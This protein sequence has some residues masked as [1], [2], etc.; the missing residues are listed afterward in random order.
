MAGHALRPPELTTPTDDPAGSRDLSAWWWGGFLGAALVLTATV[1]GVSGYW[2]RSEQRLIAANVAAVSASLIAETASRTAAVRSQLERWGRDAGVQAALADGR[3]AL[4]AAKQKEL[5]ARL[6]GTLGIGLFTPM[7]LAPGGTGADALSFAGTELVRATLASGEVSSLEAHRLGQPD[8]HLAIAGPVSAPDGGGV[9]GVVH[10]RLP[11]ALLPSKA[12]TDSMGTR[13]LFQ[14]QTGNGMVTIPLHDGDAPP[15]GEPAFT[16]PIERTHL[17]LAAWV[18]ARGLADPQRLGWLAGLLVGALALLGV[19]LWLAQRSQ[20][21]ALGADIEAL[22]AV[23]DDAQER[24]PLRA[25]R[26]RVRQ[27]LAVHERV[28][29]LLREL[30]PARVVPPRPPVDLAALAEGTLPPPAAAGMGL[31]LELD[32]PTPARP[33][34]LAQP[35]PRPPPAPR[36]SAVPAAIFRA[37]DIRGRLGTELTNEVM[38]A[39]GLALGSESLDRGSDT[40]VV[41]RDQ[42]PSSEGLSRALIDG[43]L[44][45]GVTVVDLGLMPT[46]LVYFSCQARGGTSGAMVTGSHNPSEYNGVKLVLAGQPATDADIA[47]LYERIGR[48]DFA[49]GSGERVFDGVVD[50]YVEAVEHDLAIARELRVVLDCGNATASLVAPD[51]LRHLGCEVIELDC[52]CDGELADRDIPDPSQPRKLHALTDAVRNAEADIGFGFDADGDRL[53]VVDA[54]GSY[55]SADRVM[56]LLAADVLSRLPGSDIVFDVKCSHRLAAEVLRQGGR[57]VM[58]KSGHSHLKAKLRELGAPLAGERSGHIMFADRWNGF[59]DAFYAAARLLEV[60]ALDPRDSH[61]VFAA[62]P[63][64]QG[65]QELF[66]AMPTAEATAVISAVLAMADRLEGVEVNTIDGLRAE[67]DQGWG[68]VR[69]SNTMEGLVFR[70]EADDKAS[71]DRIQNLF[72]RMMELAAPQVELPF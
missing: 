14:Q 21:L 58:W 44:A 38:G 65:T 25:P 72:R 16:G 9:I 57:P 54:L 28:R 35:A 19:V 20:R 8:A 59:D 31:E 71:L 18:P 68:L 33:A 2:L 5:A 7:M 50:A 29:R 48:G 70:F 42:R 24:R 23:M 67:F 60:L 62:L 37:N 47:G 30:Q 41:G 40:V 22:S 12:P 66:V 34:P 49:Q 17:L 32:Q 45:T 10:V 15:P 26:V 51:L 53:G 4:L 39:I 3:E 56:M 55:I 46:P 13:Y 64:G 36:G 27:L 43:L 1:A 52:D 11:L 63:A 69:A 61:E 6:P